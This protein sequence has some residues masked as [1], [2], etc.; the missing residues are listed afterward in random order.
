ML[1]T[2]SLWQMSLLLS[3]VGPLVALQSTTSQRRL[4]ASVH[5]LNTLLAAHLQ[6]P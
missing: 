4:T 6:Q 3:E 5:M 2:N 1:V